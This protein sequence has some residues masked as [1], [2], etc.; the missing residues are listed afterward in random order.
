[1]YVYVCMHLSIYR[2]I[3]LHIGLTPHLQVC[4]CC[5]VCAFVCCVCVD[6]RSCL[7]HSCCD[8]AQ[9]LPVVFLNHRSCT[10]PIHTFVCVYKGK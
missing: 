1:M 2:S 4:V 6:L 9:E 3:D 7:I 10:P 8:C 5:A